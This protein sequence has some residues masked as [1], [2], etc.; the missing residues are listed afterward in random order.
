MAATGYAL[1][2]LGMVEVAPD[3]DSDDDGEKA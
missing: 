3:D 2:D 1:P